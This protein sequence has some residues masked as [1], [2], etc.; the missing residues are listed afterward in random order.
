MSKGY[1]SMTALLGLLAVAGYQ[2]RDKIAEWLGTPARDAHGAVVPPEARTPPVGG[3]AL[4]SNLERVLGGVGSAGVGS[5]LASGLAELVEHFTTGGHGET[6]KS[7]VN[8]G[9]NKAI[10]EGDLERAIGP[11]TLDHL[12]QQTGLSR[13]EVL[14]R[15]SRDLPS[16]IDRYAIDGRRFA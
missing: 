9:D 7:W 6:A 4:P 14:A 15:L 12:T 5:L 13:S 8:Q 16:A 2:H 10:T 11:E 3:S 1:P